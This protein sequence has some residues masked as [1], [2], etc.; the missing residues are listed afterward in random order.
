VT[1]VE[2]LSCVNQLLGMQLSA[3]DVKHFFNSLYNA[4]IVFCREF[5]DL[6]LIDNYSFCT[7]HKSNT[8]NDRKRFK[9]WF[10]TYSLSKLKG[11]AED[12]VVS[13]LSKETQMILKG[14]QQDAEQIVNLD[15]K[16]NEILLSMKNQDDKLGKLYS[17]ES[18]LF[19]K[20]RV[21]IKE[22]HNLTVKIGDLVFA[23]EAV[24]DMHIEY[25]N[26]NLL[27]ESVAQ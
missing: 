14:E 4:K 18:V 3:R 24:S 27:L 10:F 1:E 12:S 26:L 9:R 5:Q 2:A 20:F 15:I 19:D 21:V 11:L 25:S 22:E 23:L 16:T 8:D 7:V 13:S 6:I 17:D